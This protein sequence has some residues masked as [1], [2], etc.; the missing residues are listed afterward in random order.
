MMKKL[1]VV[2]AI[3]VAL[4]VTVPMFAEAATVNF[5]VRF[6]GTVYGIKQCVI[7]DCSMHSQPTYNGSR[8]G[9]KA[10]MLWGFCGIRQ[11]DT[12]WI[13]WLQNGVWNKQ[14]W[15]VGSCMGVVIRV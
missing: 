6:Y 14:L 11:G 9:S 4:L 10:L 15:Y 5:T 12:I 1:L 13:K 3:A 7:V 8:V 2:L